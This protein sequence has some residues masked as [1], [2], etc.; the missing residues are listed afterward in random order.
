MEFM[1]RD[2]RSLNFICHGDHTDLVLFDQEWSP[3]RLNE[4]LDNILMDQSL[5]INITAPVITRR[6]NLEIQDTVALIERQIKEKA[7]KPEIEVKIPKQS[8]FAEFEEPPVD[9]QTKRGRTVQKPKK[10]G[11]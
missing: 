9:Y 6:D 5:S 11:K 3:L 8:S 1:S 10:Y 4:Y 2:I 7:M